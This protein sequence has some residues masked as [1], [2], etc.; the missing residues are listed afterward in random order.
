MRK[1]PALMLTCLLLLQGCQTAP[2]VTVQAVCP[3][4][5]PLETLPPDALE[6]SFTGTIANFLRGSLQTPTSYELGSK[7]ATP[8]MRLHGQP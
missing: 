4:L 3:S 5:P 1:L 8:G 2:R 7:P 6:R